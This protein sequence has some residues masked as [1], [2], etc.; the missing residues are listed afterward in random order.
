MNKVEA[1]CGKRVSPKG[2]KAHER[3][4]I[5]CQQMKDDVVDEEI[6]DETTESSQCDCIGY[7]G[8]SIT[9]QIHEH[10]TECPECHCVDQAQEIDYIDPCKIYRCKMCGLAYN[11]NMVTGDYLYS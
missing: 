1:R 8:Q 3:L 9:C 2:L 5:K 11:R 7:E 10:R 4:C 6:I